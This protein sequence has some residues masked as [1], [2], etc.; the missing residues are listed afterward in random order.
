[1]AL[2]HV[3]QDIVR[4]ELARGSDIVSVARSLGCSI[5]E[6]REIGI[7]LLPPITRTDVPL[8]PDWGREEL[9]QF[10]VAKKRP[11][12]EWPNTPQIQRAKVDYD[13]GLVE[14][15][16]GR[17]RTIKGPMLILYVIPRKVPAVRGPYFGRNFNAG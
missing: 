12:D 7:S 15:A 16:T 4:N 3:E 8:G 13:A 11:Q 14:M 17:A 10:A 1:M 2:T 6:V 5:R 9:Q